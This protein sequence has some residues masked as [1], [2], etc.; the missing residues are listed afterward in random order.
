MIVLLKRLKKNIS[1]VILSLKISFSFFT[2]LRYYLRFS[3]GQGL[4]SKDKG[5]ASILLIVHSLEK[6]LSFQ[7]K[8]DG[9]GGGKAKELITLI[10]AYIKRYG[11]DKVT[12]IAISVLDKYFKDAF[13]SGDVVI[14]EK[15]ALLCMENN[16]IV[17]GDLGG[18]K[19]LYK[20]DFELTY[21]SIFD[22]YE[23]RKSVRDFSD[24]PITDDEIRKALLLA[25]TTPTACNRQT[26]MVY[27]FK[28]KS[29]M[30]SLIQIQ[31]GDQGW[32]MNADTLFVISGNQSYFGGVYERSQVF[33]DGGLYAMNFMMG[34]HAQ[35]IA[36]CFKM[37]VREPEIDKEF[38]RI[39]GLP[40]NEIPIVLIL[41]GHYPIYPSYIPISKRL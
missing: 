1:R 27:V 28:G 32:C 30:N 26:S 15:Y 41:A 7:N 21:S 22:Y 2:D 18:V 31:C 23:Q 38:R 35:K 20:P 8:K 9:F 37:Y 14:R 4:N 33:I 25:K 3:L 17:N 34:L 39:A 11:Q 6:G 36:S 19:H 29:V 12:S 13:A 10:D 5:K 16:C 24:E 40:E